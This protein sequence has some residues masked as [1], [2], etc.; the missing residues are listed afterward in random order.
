M[1]AKIKGKVVEM[2]LED[3]KKLTEELKKCRKDKEKLIKA[4]EFLNS[5]I[6]EYNEKFAK[7]N[8]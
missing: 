5:Q 1:Q 2:P 7:S 8:D 3:F 4:N 6:K